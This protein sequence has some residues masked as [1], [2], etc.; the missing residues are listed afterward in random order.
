MK[1]S[2]VLSILFVFLLSCEKAADVGHP[3]DYNK[4]GLSFQYPGNW[5][6]TEGEPDG[7]Y[8]YINIKSPGNAL[9]M[10]LYFKDLESPMV[11][12]N[13]AQTM[14]S[15]FKEELKLGSMREEDFKGI[16]GVVSSNYVKGV[17]ETFVLDMYG[18]VVP[19]HRDYYKAERSN[20]VVLFLSQAADEDS[21]IA[22]TG[23][24]FIRNTFRFEPSVENALP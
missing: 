18:T 22:E 4:Q 20:D 24:E 16:E 14:S 8:S 10:V 1:K 7:N 19:H 23:F 5:K 2:C 17:R 13:I 15:M 21:E 12:I 6:L 9:M 3:Q 11:L